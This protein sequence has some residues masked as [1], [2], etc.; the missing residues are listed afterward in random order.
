M[1]STGIDDEYRADITALPPPAVELG[2]DISDNPRGIEHHLPA[3][4]ATTT[5]TTTPTTRDREGMAGRGETNVDGSHGVTVPADA[6][7]AN[8]DKKPPRAA[9]IL[10]CV[11]GAEA[12]PPL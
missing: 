8:T 10:P 7:G 11:G 4:A 2:G 12:G 3:A 9:P 6:A 5:A 1:T